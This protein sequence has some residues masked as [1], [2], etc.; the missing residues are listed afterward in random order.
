MEQPTVI[1][2]SNKKS[3]LHE[4]LWILKL[5][6]FLNLSMLIFFIFFHIFKLLILILNL[7]CV[8]DVKILS[9]QE[10]KV[11][12]DVLSEPEKY[13]RFIRYII[14]TFFRYINGNMKNF[15]KTD[16][17]NLLILTWYQKR[18]KSKRKNALSYIF[19]PSFCHFVIFTVLLLSENLCVEQFWV[20]M[21]I[22]LMSLHICL[23]SRWELWLS[24]HEC[25]HVC[26]N[27]YIQCL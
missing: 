5:F 11:S 16:V 1:I 9:D 18:K 25:P 14:F 8:N 2:W 27:I 20:N 13:L 3:F 17:C 23:I 19:A 22:E 4:D 10:K 6:E 15:K 7:V 24:D 12:K 21:V 26:L